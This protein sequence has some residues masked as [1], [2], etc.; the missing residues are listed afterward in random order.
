MFGLA[1]ILLH[2]LMENGH[3]FCMHNLVTFFHILISFMTSRRARVF[4]KNIYK[5]LGHML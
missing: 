3:S 2:M 1:K 5:I 4:K